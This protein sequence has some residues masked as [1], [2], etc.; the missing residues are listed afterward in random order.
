VIRVAEETGDPLTRA[1]VYWSQSRLHSMRHE[2][3]L[4]GRYARRALEILERT[5]NDAYV[6][7]AYHL[8]AHSEVQAGHG[9]EALRLLARGRELLGPELSARD[10]A[11]FSTEESRALILAG[12]SRDAARAAAHALELLDALG[13]GDR[14]LAYVA[15]ADVFRVV[16]D[17]DRAKMLLG[18]AL[19]LLL[20]HGAVRALEAARP[21]AEILED[22]G[23]TTGALSVLKRAAAA[24]AMPPVPVTRG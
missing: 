11:R 1:R 19:D 8:L 6:G 16:E 2:P 24:A 15:L 21:L 12:R 9:E 13:P 22:E 20:A 5:E 7:M 18:Q 17:R 23:D 10:D 14:G 4:A 3:Q